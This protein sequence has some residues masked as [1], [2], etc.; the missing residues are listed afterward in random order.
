MV[1][2]FLFA[3]TPHTFVHNL[4]EDHRDTVDG[5]HKHPGISDVHIHCEFLRISLS[6][7]LPGHLPVYHFIS[8][9]FPVLFIVPAISLPVHDVFHQFLR[10]P[11]ETA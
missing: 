2:V 5:I 11:P 1:A 7:T 8:K 10:G 3:A 6:P 9:E 4:I